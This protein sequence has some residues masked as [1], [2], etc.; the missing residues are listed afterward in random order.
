ICIHFTRRVALFYMFFYFYIISYYLFNYSSKI[1]GFL[2]K[3][4]KIFC[5][6]GLLIVGLFLY[7]F[8]KYHYYQIERLHKIQYYRNIVQQ[9]ISLEPI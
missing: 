3:N 6:G 4:Y 5:F 2:T 8:G 7:I 9:N 1:N